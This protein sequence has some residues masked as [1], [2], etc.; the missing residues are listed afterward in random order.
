M[1]EEIRYAV[2]KLYDTTRRRRTTSRSTARRASTPEASIVRRPSRRQRESS[3]Q[4]QPQPTTK[5]PTRRREARNRVRIP[6]PT[7]PCSANT[8]D[9]LRYRAQQPPL[10]DA[11]MGS[12]ASPARNGNRLSQP[13]PPNDP[14]SVLPRRFTTDS[15]RV[16]TMS[17]ITAQRAAEPQD[18]SATAVRLP[19]W[20]FMLFSGI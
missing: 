8:M 18:M 11:T 12:F 5:F 14:R 16:P 2:T 20:T 17:S 6:S 10:G 1:Y 15:G 13:V 7:K 4:T 19:P 9:E 3:S